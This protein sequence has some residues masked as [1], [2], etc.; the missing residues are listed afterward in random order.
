[1]RILFPLLLCLAAAA[2]DARRPLLTLTGPKSFVETAE[3][4]RARSA[5]EFEKLWL[6]HAGKTEND[7]FYNAAGVP[8]IDFDRCMVIAVFQG[9]GWNSAGLRVEAL[10]EEEGR[11]LLRFDDK[12]Y[13][14]EGPDGG[15]VRVTAYGFFVLP[16]SDKPVVVEEDVQDL[17]GAPPK[18]KE[19]AR[20]AAISE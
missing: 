4:H 3:A 10:I 18:W 19:R 11:I 2:G 9:M 13:Q 5:A 6:R 20:F 12:S 17:I 15:G 16:R 1:M 7:A 8:D 14:T